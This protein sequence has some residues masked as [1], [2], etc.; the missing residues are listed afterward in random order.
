MD[1]HAFVIFNL[2][3]ISVNK[4]KH[5]IIFRLSAMGD[6]AMTVPVIRALV[7]QY[8]EVK[9]TVV[10]RPFFSPFFKDI[11]NVHFFAVDVKK[12]HKGFVGLLRLFQD[13]K[14]LKVDYFA[15]FHAVLRSSIIGG[16]FKLSGVKCSTLDKGRKEKKALTRAENK[17]FSPVKTMFDNH[18]E[19]L[20]RLGFNVSLATPSF[21][22]KPILAKELIPFVDN[23]KKYKV[24]IAPFAQYDTKVYPLD[25]MQEVVDKLAEIESVQ[26]FLFGGG[27]KE[28]S[29]LNQLKRDNENVVVMAGKVKF[30]VELN[31]IQHLDVMLSMDSGN[32][33]IAAMLGVKVV[34]LW[35][36]THPYAGFAPF[37]QP[38]AYSLTVDRN[39]YPLIPTSV[40]GN[41]EI[42][43]YKDAMRTIKPS[44]V[45]DKILEVMQKDF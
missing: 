29:L 24:G 15:D 33:H 14:V 9:V 31:L 16:L 27:E 8:P 1:N 26:V 17:V 20:K 34:T 22:V 21:P 42:I 10:S 3:C 37:Y 11:P 12:R 4:R 41:K 5:I 6:V 38:L 2:I 7:E 36:A 19:T 25:L 32:G 23:N 18:C 28:I 35:G 30:E 13:L 39:Q 43:D 40:Y 45:C 44:A